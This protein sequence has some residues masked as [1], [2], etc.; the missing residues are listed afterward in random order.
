MSASFDMTVMTRRCVLLFVVLALCGFGASISNAESAEPKPDESRLERL[1]EGIRER[2]ERFRNATPE[3][4]DMRRER[5]HRQLRDASPR[6]RRRILRR[7]GRLMYVLPEEEREKIRKENQAF[8]EKHGL[9]S[10]EEALDAARERARELARELDLTPEEGR[11]LRR[12]FREL[13]RKEREALWQDIQRFREL[14]SDERA[15]LEARLLELKE[16]GEE[17]RAVMRENARRWSQMPE[18]KRERLRAQWRKLRALP[19]QE[20]AE[21][22]ER[23]LELQ[24]EGH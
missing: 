13:P 8:R 22:L 5:L 11:A 18:E 12:R 6:E 14:P 20:R 19:P 16:L 23:A 15:A 4:R 10:I 21:L 24:E 9:P 1:P 7:E 3:E 17:D 2:V